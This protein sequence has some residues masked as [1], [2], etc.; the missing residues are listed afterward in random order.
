MSYT[1]ARRDTYGMYQ[2]TGKGPGPFF[3]GAGTLL[4]E[5]V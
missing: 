2:K 3:M 5:D 1:D 4:G